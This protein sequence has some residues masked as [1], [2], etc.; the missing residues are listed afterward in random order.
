MIDFRR[1]GGRRR[2]RQSSR[3]V[4]LGIRQPAGTRRKARR[5]LAGTQPRPRRRLDLTQFLTLCAALGTLALAIPQLIS[6]NAQSHNL[7]QQQITERFSKAVEQ[8]GNHDNLEIR[9]GGIYSL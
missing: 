4:G 2:A 8:L 1:A 7:E 5:A 9:L 6:A 3:P